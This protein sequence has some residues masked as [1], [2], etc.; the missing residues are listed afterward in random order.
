MS[1]RKKRVLSPEEQRLWEAVKTTATP[2]QPELKTSVTSE[3][4]L[5]RPKK[6]PVATDLSP[7]AAPKQPAKSTTGKSNLVP[8][9]ADRLKAAPV[10]MDGRTYRKMNRG[11]L[12]PE[13]RIDLHG[14]TLDQAHPALDRF[15][16]RAHADGKRLVLVI[17]G[18]GKP[19]DD[20]GP[21][22][23]RL[24]VLRHQVPNWLAQGALAPMVLQV[25]L[26]SPNYGGSGAYFVYLRRQR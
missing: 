22:P 16:R 17:T 1:R 4:A 5:T 11:K 19:R 10:Q 13:A 9:L 2:L 3:F 26:A 18:K 23:T 24:G 21:I 7:L 8:E 12:R 14:M 6:K 20:G 25:T 15:I